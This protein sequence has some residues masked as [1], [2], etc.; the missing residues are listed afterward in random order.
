MVDHTLNLSTLDIITDILR[1]SSI[2]L[3]AY[4]ERSAQNLLHTTL[5]LLRQR[6]ESHR[7]GNLN[8]LIEGNGLAVLDI[9]LLLSVSGW[10]LQRLD[11][12]RR[13]RWD[14]GNGGLSVLD[15]KLHC[16]TKT[17]LYFELVRP[18]ISVYPQNIVPTQSPVAFAISSPTFFGDRPRGPILGA[19]A[20]EAPTSPPVALKWLYI[21]GQY[22]IPARMTR[23]SPWHRLAVSQ[24][25]L[26]EGSE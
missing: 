18:A 9:L 6:L 20:E 15:G 22:N 5:K 3:A 19:S 1:T 12:E 4:A 26:V 21:H 10:L 25:K 16:D 8:D 11:D 24:R 13:G 2:N 14:D 17:F 7:P 23:C